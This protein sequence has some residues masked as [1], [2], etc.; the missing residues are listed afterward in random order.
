MVLDSTTS[1]LV[2]LLQFLWYSFIFFWPF[3]NF[4]FYDNVKK[5]KNL[6]VTGHEW[7]LKGNCPLSGKS[8]E[9]KVNWLL[10]AGD[11]GHRD[12]EVAANGYEVSFGEI[13]CYKIRL[14]WWWHNSMNILE[15][16]E[17]YTVSELYTMWII[18]RWSHVF[19]KRTLFPT[20]HHGLR[21]NI[22]GF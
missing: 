1:L 8:V 18:S 16:I 2:I 21:R 22:A 7:Q 4:S 11:S 6:S 9:T 5:R 12:W 14:K 3:F 20:S 17:S 10:R 19:L 15:N 13:K